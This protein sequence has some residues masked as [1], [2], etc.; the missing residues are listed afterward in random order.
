MVKC[1][2]RAYE[3]CPTRHLCGSI[4]EAVFME[5]CKCDI[6]NQRILNQPMTEGDRFR[7]LSDEDLADTIYDLNMEGTFCTNRKECFEK[8]NKDEITDEMCKKCLLEWLRKP[9][10]GPKLPSGIFLDKQESGL[11]E[12]A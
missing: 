9:A 10:E 6:F 1:H 3:K 8:L 12:E 4:H 11:T 7:T 5:G 2:P